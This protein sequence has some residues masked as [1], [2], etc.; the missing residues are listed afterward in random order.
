[1]PKGV[2]SIA[3]RRKVWTTEDEW[4]VAD[5]LAE[6]RTYA[7]IA[8][9][10]GRSTNSVKVYCARNVKVLAVRPY[11]CRTV[12]ELLGLGCAK[13]VA[14]WI[15]RGWLSGAR[16]SVG[17][18]V[19]RRWIVT[20][21]ALLAFLADPAHWQRWDAERITNRE[22][23][24][25]ATETRAE[26]YWTQAEVAKRFSVVTGTVGAWLDRGFLAY[27]DTGSHRMV[28]ESDLATFVMPSERQKAGKTA[29]RFTPE[30]DARLLHL[31]DVER[32]SWS[33]CEY[34]LRRALGS[35]AGRYARLKAQR[36]E[37]ERAA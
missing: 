15:E 8:K 14:K 31:R 12:A 7:Q 35:C 37:D 22:L 25:W 33:E 9:R 23:R 26:R 28:R 30:E 6:G 36:T 2:Y 4:A 11:S 3:G 29:R 32:A 16:S 24:E 5:G 13:T 20:E 1:M 19:A 34:Q 10:L 18:G 17:A 21:D 27:V